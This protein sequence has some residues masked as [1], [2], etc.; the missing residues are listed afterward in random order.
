MAAFVISHKALRSEIFLTYKGKIL[1]HLQRAKM[2]DFD[3]YKAMKAKRMVSV[4][5]LSTKSS[6]W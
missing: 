1:L 6:S 2:S 5:R 3:R 4:S